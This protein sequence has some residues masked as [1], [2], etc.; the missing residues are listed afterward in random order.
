[1]SREQIDSQ[2]VFRIVA[3]ALLTIAGAALLGLIVVK[4]DTTIRWL[5]TAIFLALVLAPGVELIGRV[6]IRGWQPPRWLAILLTF[7]LAFIALFFLVLVVDHL[8]AQ[9]LQLGVERILGVARIEDVVDE[10]LG[11]IVL[12]PQEHELLLADLEVVE[13]RLER[14]EAQLK[15]KRTD[16]DAREQAVLLEI[17]PALEAGRPIRALGLGEE[18]AGGKERR[19]EG[20]GKRG[21]EDGYRQEA[22]VHGVGVV[23]DRRRGKRV[24]PRRGLLAQGGRTTQARAQSRKRVRTRIPR[25]VRRR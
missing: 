15:K 13:R 11:G 5:V 16:A 25:R 21:G 8:F 17:K 3:V 7:A 1:M 22:H 9:H 6:R 24:T 4:V 2:A 23:Q 12:D 10:D 18:P 19:N 20:G 14:L